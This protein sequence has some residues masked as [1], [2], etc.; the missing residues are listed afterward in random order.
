[1]SELSLSP[2][3]LN[4]I[5]TSWSKI[6][7]KL[8]FFNDLYLNLIEKNPHLS[9][10]FNHDHLVIT[11]HARIFG[12]VF[13][14]VVTHL[15][16]LVLV[17]D[18]I[19]LF[20]QENQRFASMSTKYLEPMGNALI[21]TLKQT[22]QGHCS[23]VLELTWV[24]VYVFFANSVLLCEEEI[25][26]EVSS[27]LDEAEVPPL[28]LSR[29]R[30]R[31]SVDTLPTPPP[32]QEPE[33]QPV[34][35]EVHAP[36][37]GYDN[38]KP[39]QVLDKFNSIEIDLKANDKYKGFRRSV[40]V[41]TTPVKVAIP[42]APT[43]QKSTSYSSMLS[44]ASTSAPQQSNMSS[45]LKNMLADEEEYYK[46]PKP[47]F[48]P[49]RRRGASACA[50]PVHAPSTPKLQ[51][52]ASSFNE[53]GFESPRMNPED[54]DDEFVTPSHSRRGSFSESSAYPASSLLAKLK[55]YQDP[56]DVEEEEDAA[57]V[58]DNNSDDSIDVPTFD[59]RQRRRRNVELNKQIPS[60]ESSEVDEQEEE[61][62]FINKFKSPSPP[63]KQQQ[64]KQAV[65][66]RSLSRG[67]LTGGTFDYQSFGLKGLAPIVED[68][69]VSSKYESDG[70]DSSSHNN[71]KLSTKSSNQS[72]T[73]E[74][75]SRASSL[76]LHHSDYKSSF[77]SSHGETDSLGLKGPS[78]LRHEVHSRATS[79]GTDDFQFAA[80][81]QK[82]QLG[83]QHRKNHSIYSLGAKSSMSASSV[84]STGRASLGFMRSS[85]VL[86][87]EMETQ[88][89][90]HPENVVM[91][92]LASVP[93]S[94]N[95]NKKSSSGSLQPPRN[96]IYLNNKA[97]SVS[98]FGGSRN[99]S[100]GFAVDS[101]S[102]SAYNLINSFAPPP[103]PAK[104]KLKTSH[105]GY[106][107]QPKKKS[108]LLG[109]LTS[110]FSS[111][112]SSPKTSPSQSRKNSIASVPTQ[113]YG[114]SYAASTKSSSGGREMT[115]RQYY[116]EQ[117]SLSSGKPQQP[118]P[119]F[120]ARN[121]SVSH[122]PPVIHKIESSGC[123]ISNVSSKKGSTG[124]SSVAGG[125]SGVYGY[126]YGSHHDL[127]SVHTSET[128]TSGFSMLKTANK[129]DVK[130]V[131]PLTRHTRKGNK[132]N[133]KKVPYNIWK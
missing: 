65:P 66:E 119:L 133:V 111:R 14:F 9:A 127:N 12:D 67:G 91:G 15:D 45:T 49:R 88:G 99:R 109:K 5:R 52:S 61:D 13:S 69:D 64:Q 90:N 43:F 54:T 126:K 39:V 97:N 77:V 115:A 63:A 22:L 17:D 25:R 105:Y 122:I 85:F 129:N 130:F 20:V 110:I 94:P 50:S 106:V 32:R 71:D 58:C 89:F 31:P 27:V 75:N 28:N 83:Q 114:S 42:S 113:S 120:A 41:A 104:D 3:E 36:V 117:Q 73:D 59:P 38:S 34:K 108:G 125:S 2:V 55:K 30:R 62:L 24:K 132:Y 107:D 78:S 16:D 79:V 48:D 44:T 1:M 96:S 118:A 74:S 23:N 8:G 29:D 131:P 51:S 68:D 4:Q 40:D 112:S 46:S 57:V 128:S 123:S 82:S 76:S 7:H 19:F 11:Q 102:D 93:V 81:Q 124:A 72:S 56:V 21:A 121:A 84:S 18:F 37:I 26:S 100:S 47:S 95:L 86:K 6:T 92:G 98:S 116:Q 10:I 87:K 80:P 53:K 103:V 33:P 60:P 101:P 70:D 35:E